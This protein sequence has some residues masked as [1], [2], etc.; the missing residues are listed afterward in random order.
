MRVTCYPMAMRWLALAARCFGV[1]GLISGYAIGDAD[2][3][4]E[5]NESPPLTPA[6]VIF[7]GDISG[8]S[9]SSDSTGAEARYNNSQRT[10]G[11]APP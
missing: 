2:G 6:F 4:A 1:L 5:G 9:R 7:A 10:P 8:P 3:G 11:S